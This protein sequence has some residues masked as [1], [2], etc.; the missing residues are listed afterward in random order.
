MKKII[1]YGTGSYV[2]GNEYINPVILPSVLK[3]IHTN[4]IKCE[5]IFAKRSNKDLN[6]IKLK[7]NSIINDFKIS[8]NYK[9]YPTSKL[10]IQEFLNKFKTDDIICSIICT[11]DHEHYKIALNC[12][13]KFIN[14]IVVKPLVLTVKENQNLIKI[15]KK[16]NCIG[17]VDYHKRFDN[18][19]KLIKRFNDTQISNLYSIDINYSQKKIVSCNIFDWVEKSNILNYLGSHYIDFVSHTSGFIPKSVMAIGIKK[20]LFSKKINTF[21]SIICLVKWGNGKNE[22]IMNLKTNWIDPLY[23]TSMSD[24]K[25]IMHYTNSKIISDQKNRGFYVS[26]DTNNFESLNPDFNQKYEP[27][28]NNNNVYQGYGIDSIVTLLEQIQKKIQKVKF[29]YQDYPNIEQSLVV[30]KVLEGASKSLK[31]NSTWVK[32]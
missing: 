15:S 12:F 11:P 6:K 31:N 5:L 22:F 29:N 9:V 13:K 14:I 28:S 4:N 17:F 1:I 3:F 16:N 18:H 24:Q 32:I 8:I 23:E 19:S 30:S 20:Y 10:K 21:D 26:S 7:I 27:V 2:L 25:V